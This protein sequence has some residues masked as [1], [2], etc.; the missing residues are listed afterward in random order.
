MISEVEAR[1]LFVQVA[2]AFGS[3]D[4]D[5]DFFCH[6]KEADSIDPDPK[7]FVEDILNATVVEGH[8]KGTFGEDAV[9]T[10][11]HMLRNGEKG[12]M[13]SIEVSLF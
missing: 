12:R 5:F 13:C 9:K 7:F 3:E 1:K 4:H 8:E 6:D 10:I 2:L 11:L